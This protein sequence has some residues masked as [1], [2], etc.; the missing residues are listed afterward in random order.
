MDRNFF[1]FHYYQRQEAPGPFGWSVSE[2]LGTSLKFKS[3][4]AVQQ[5]C[6]W[7]LASKDVNKGKISRCKMFWLRCSTCFCRWNP[8]PP[9]WISLDLL[10]ALSS[11]HLSDPGPLALAMCQS[12]E[13]HSPPKPCSCDTSRS[14]VDS[15]QFVTPGSLIALSCDGAFLR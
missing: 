14:C 12:V 4:F 1:L 3:F 6:L 11:C 13:R 2:V 8:R 9:H 5:K 7:I 15:T 10:K